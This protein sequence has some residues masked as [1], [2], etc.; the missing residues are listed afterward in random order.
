MEQ[1]ARRDSVASSAPRL[2]QRIRTS[3]TE[4]S[5]SGLPRLSC[6]AVGHLVEEMAK[7]FPE[8]PTEEELLA[9][10]LDPRLKRHP[11]VFAR[12]N[13]AR[14]LLESRLELALLDAFEDDEEA[15]ATA[16][17]GAGDPAVSLLPTAPLA[18][19]AYGPMRRFSSGTELSAARAAAAPLFD[20]VRKTAH[21]K[22][23]ELVVATVEAW[24]SSPDVN[25]PVMGAGSSAFNL[26]KFYDNVAFDKTIP[27]VAVEA[28]KRVGRASFGWKASAAGP[29][30]IFSY[31]GL[32]CSALKNRYSVEMLA[33]MVFLKKNVKFMPSVEEVVFEMKRMKQA[34]KDAKRA[35]AKASKAAK[36]AS[37][38]SSSSCAGASGGGGAD[39]DVA[40]DVENDETDDEEDLPDFDSSSSLSDS[41]VASL[42]TSIADF[43]SDVSN[44]EEESDFLNFLTELER[45]D[46]N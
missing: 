20:M 30:K 2:H 4:V 9:A 46:S 7:Y 28:F 13:Y 34:A 14:T 25:A 8:D 21:E 38:S 44:A 29:E 16:D 12:T 3:A 40:E 10:F 1:A 6:L 24:V 27:V 23:R 37:S 11:L 17:T 32:T 26:L 31:A 22:T 5:V 41:D 19:S 15:P 43:R 18:F 33:I 39:A 45:V 35:A 36:T 42:L